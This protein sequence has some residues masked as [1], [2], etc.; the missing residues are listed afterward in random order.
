MFYFILKKNRHLLFTRTSVRSAQGPPCPLSESTQRGGMPPFLGL[1]TCVQRT[2][3]LA[4][5]SFLPIEHVLLAIRNLN[6]RIKLTC[7]SRTLYT[8]EKK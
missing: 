3:Y 6:V 2:A 8:V 4:S 1:T 7:R 5:K